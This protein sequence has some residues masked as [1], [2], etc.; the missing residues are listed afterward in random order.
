MHCTLLHRGMCQ[1]IVA[2]QQCA[3][4]LQQCSAARIPLLHR[5]HEQHRATPPRCTEHCC[6]AAACNTVTVLRCL[7]DIFSV[8]STP[9]G[10]A[11]PQIPAWS[12]PGIHCRCDRIPV[13]IPGMMTTRL[14]IP[15]WLGSIPSLVS[16]RQTRPSAQPCIPRPQSGDKK[17]AA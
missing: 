17:Y 14:T 2:V 1:A 8:R 12:T 4:T 16:T 11:Q 6:D 13:G 15:A 5:V 9:Q 10:C 7:T 3:V